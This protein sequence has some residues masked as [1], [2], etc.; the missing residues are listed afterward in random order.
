MKI[1]IRDI[2]FLPS[3]AAKY[4]AQLSAVHEVLSTL[5]ENQSNFCDGIQHSQT[6]LNERKGARQ[7]VELSNTVQNTKKSVM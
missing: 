7:A 3:W 2:D 6:Q 4:H 1:S 5:L